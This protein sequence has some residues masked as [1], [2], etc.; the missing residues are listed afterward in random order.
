MDMQTKYAELFH[1]SEWSVRT[2]HLRNI[3]SLGAKNNQMNCFGAGCSCKLLYEI[4]FCLKID[5]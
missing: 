2:G 1:I 4:L 3:L 5:Y